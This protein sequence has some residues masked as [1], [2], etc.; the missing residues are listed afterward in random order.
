[1]LWYDSIFWLLSLYDNEYDFYS[2]CTYERRTT[3]RSLSPNN[4]IQPYLLL[5]MQMQ[6]IQLAIRS[7]F[8]NSPIFATLLIIQVLVLI[9]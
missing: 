4:I 9:F 2:Q 8:F 7:G 6:Y 3:Y 1:M 5:P